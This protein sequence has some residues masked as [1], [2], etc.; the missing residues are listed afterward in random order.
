MS[1]SKRR[2]E[3]RERKR[4]WDRFQGVNELAENLLREGGLLLNQVCL[5][6]AELV[7]HGFLQDLCGA[8]H[9]IQCP[10]HLANEGQL[11]RFVVG[12]EGGD[13]RIQTRHQ[14]LE[15]LLRRLPVRVTV[16]LEVLTDRNQLFLCLSQ[17][18]Y[19]EESRGGGEVS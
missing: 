16:T 10:L 17:I 5:P 4:E 6:L 12:A 18:V 15:E 11:H 8:V 7:V 19:I 13:H 14:L 1:N 3:K 2:E 9:E